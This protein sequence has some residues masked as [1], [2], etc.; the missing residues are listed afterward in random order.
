MEHVWMDVEGMINSGDIV[1]RYIKLQKYSPTKETGDDITMAVDK[2]KQLAV[3]YEH[4]GGRFGPAKV[5][6]DLL[7]NC[8]ANHGDGKLLTCIE[9]TGSPVK[10]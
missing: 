1:Y 8:V 9:G 6:E 5:F 4:A 10:K 7:V 3:D 2:L